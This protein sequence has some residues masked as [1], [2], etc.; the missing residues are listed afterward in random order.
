VI[1]ITGTGDHLRPDWPI[2][3]TGMRNIGMEAPVAKA[4]ASL[5]PKPKASKTSHQRRVVAEAEW[6]AGEANPRFV[7]TS[8]SLQDATPRRLYEEIYCARS[9]TRWSFSARPNR[10][11]ET[12]GLAPTHQGLAGKPRAARCAPAA[13]GRGSG[14]GRCLAGGTRPGNEALLSPTPSK[15]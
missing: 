3:F 10:K 4:T 11:I 14:C 2:T 9:A 15:D 6:T 5:P 13:S 1:T 12:I 8:L 7:V